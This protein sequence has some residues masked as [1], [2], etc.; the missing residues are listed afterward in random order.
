MITLLVIDDEEAILH[1]FRR[2][3]RAPDFALHTASAA[4]EGLALLTRVRPDV[5]ILDVHLP[6]ASGLDTFARIHQADERL[7]VV[8][9]TGH[10]TTDLAIEAIKRGA[11]DYLLKPLELPQL[12]ELV[13]RAAATHRLMTIPAAMPEVE[14]APA[15]AD[16]LLGRCPAMQEVYKAIG[17]VARQEVAVLILGE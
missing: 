9:V 11:Y 17:R 10:G 1:A 15:K 13:T 3:F 2:A 12:R 5:V 7:P 16:F 8:L 14:A 6:D 4:A